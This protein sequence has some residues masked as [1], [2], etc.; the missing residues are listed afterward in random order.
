VD[1]FDRTAQAK[2]ASGTL[3]TLD[4]QIDT[5]T[6]TIRFRG[7]FTNRDL[8][9]FPNQFVNARLLVHTIKDAVLIPNAAIQRNGA[10]AFV[11]VVTNNRISIRNV[12]ERGADGTATAV[13]GLRVG[14]RVALSSFDKLEDGTSVTVVQEAGNVSGLRTGGRL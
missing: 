14:E 11:F 9:L 3:L 8:A 13:E 5:S 12:T 10:Q 7:E 1:A 2:I 4:N 6:G